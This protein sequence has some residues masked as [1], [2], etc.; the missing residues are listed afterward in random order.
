VPRAKATH[1][2]AQPQATAMNGRV[3]HALPHDV[4]AL[5]QLEASFPS[6]RLSRRSFRHLIG[7]AHADVLVFEWQNKIAGDAVVLYRRNTRYARLYSL[8]VAPQYQQQGI[9]GTLVQTAEDAAVKRGCVRIG[10]ELR[11][12]NH[13]ALRLYQGR[14]Y[15]LARR[16]EDYYEDGSAALC[17]HKELG[18]IKRVVRGRHEGTPAQTGV[19]VVS[20][21]TA[22]PPKLKKD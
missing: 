22:C 4:P 13:A 5:L 18:R 12:D 6:D 15:V 7:K 1:H 10:L 14:G 16:K 20:T 21:P 9:A 2:P 11:T 8:V 19:P 17:M 3:R